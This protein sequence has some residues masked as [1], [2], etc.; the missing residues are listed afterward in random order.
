M[1]PGGKG[2]WGARSGRDPRMGQEVRRQTGVQTEVLRLT[3]D[4]TWLDMTLVCTRLVCNDVWTWLMGSLPL[5][6][7]CQTQRQTLL[8]QTLTSSSHTE[9]IRQAWPPLYK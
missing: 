4:V 8:V 9:F 5:V 3:I 6:N 1:S 2:S 7:V